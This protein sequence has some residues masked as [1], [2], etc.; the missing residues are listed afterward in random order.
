MPR[1]DPRVVQRLLRTQASPAVEDEQRAQEVLRRRRQAIEVGVVI[2]ITCLDLPLQNGVLIAAE[3]WAAREE[4]PSDDTERPHVGLLRVGLPE[5]LRRHEVGGAAGLGHSA[6]V[7]PELR[8]AEVDDLDLLLLVIGEHHVLG[9]DVPVD[10]LLRQVVEVAQRIA[11]LIEVL[12]SELVGERAGA[13][14]EV[15]HAAALGELHAEVDV[16][17]VAEVEEELDDVLVPQ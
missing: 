1:L 6:V 15:E 16:A 3:G 2:D 10:D 13:A 17:V 7:V 8:E 9:L 5:H 4:H 14:E 12:R 11:D